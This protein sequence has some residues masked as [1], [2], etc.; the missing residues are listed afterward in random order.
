MPDN[1]IRI[2]FHDRLGMPKPE[3]QLTLFAGPEKNSPAPFVHPALGRMLTAASGELHPTAF[4]LARALATFMRE[5]RPGVF[6]ARPSREGILARAGLASLTT[7][8]RH[9]PAALAAFGIVVDRARRGAN[10]YRWPVA[11]RNPDTTVTSFL[12]GPRYGPSKRVTR[13]RCGPGHGPYGGP[14]DGPYGG[15]LTEEQRTRVLS[16]AAKSW[17]CPEAKALLARAG[18]VSEEALA[19]RFQAV[20]TAVLLPGRFLAALD[21]SLSEGSRD[22]WGS[23]LLRMQQF[24]KRQPAAKR[25]EEFDALLAGRKAPVR[26]DAPDTKEDA[27]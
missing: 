17:A 16:A 18:V 23:A 27:G 11:S 3:K 6:S 8:K 19:E 12:K 5:E 14:P 10:T 26:R 21:L 15:P 7:Y 25:V 9:M 20:E 2:D 4:L 24:S 1:T 22:P 13:S